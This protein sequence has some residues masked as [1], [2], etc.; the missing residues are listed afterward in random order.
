M[1]IDTLYICVCNKERLCDEDM[2]KKKACLYP[3]AGTKE[4]LEA[5]KA[6]LLDYA[7][8]AGYEVTDVAAD[9][10]PSK[11]SLKLVRLGASN[12]DFE[13]LLISSWNRLGRDLSD[14]LDT[15]THL[16]NQNVAVQSVK[17]KNMS[18]NR[19]L[20]IARF[21]VTMQILDEAPSEGPDEAS[22][23]GLEKSEPFDMTQSF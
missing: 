15:M 9:Y 10:S 18:L 3:R 19:A 4:S 20:S 6:L 14:A 2:D 22:S 23:E 8:E 11:G 5:Q 16:K 1:S 13:V 21:A 12:H 17:E 7:N